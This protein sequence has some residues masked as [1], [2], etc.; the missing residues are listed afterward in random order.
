MGYYDAARLEPDRCSG[1]GIASTPARAPISRL[2][3]PMHIDH[4]SRARYS[5]DN[6]GNAAINCDVQSVAARSCTCSLP[7]SVDT[8]LRLGISARND[9]LPCVSWAVVG[10]GAG[11]TPDSAGKLWP[12]VRGSVGRHHCQS[13][14]GQRADVASIPHSIVFLLQ[15]WLVLCALCGGATGQVQAVTAGV[16]FACVLTT[17]QGVRCVGDNHNGQIDIGSSSPVATSSLPSSDAIAAVARVS[18]TFAHVCA[19]STSNH[20]YCWGHGASYQLGTGGSAT[21]LA[22]PILPVLADVVTA[23]TG[24]DF[25]CVLYTSSAVE[26]WGDK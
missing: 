2:L 12:R 5:F 21:L 1:H 18:G 11:R 26:C 9:V 17:A 23:A 6:I 19:V 22:P 16:N 8:P 14:V 7:S 10:G 24:L 20:L 15:V 13:A 4:C 3:V 25:T